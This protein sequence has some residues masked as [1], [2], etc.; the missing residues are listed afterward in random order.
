MSKPRPDQPEPEAKRQK[1]PI[2]R[3][4]RWPLRA[5]FG[6]VAS[7]LLYILSAAVLGLIP[8]NSD[9]IQATSGR[10]VYVI[11]NG[12]HTSFILP[13]GNGAENL[14][15]FVPFEKATDVNCRYVQFGWG[16]R[17]F[18]L[19]TPNWS[20]LEVSTALKSVLLPSSTVVHVTYW[21]WQPQPNER[22]RRI[23]LSDT[24][25]GRLLDHIKNSFTFDPSG[26]TQ[27][28]PGAGY[29]DRDAFFEAQGSYSLL[30]TCNDWTNTGLKHA[31]V[32]TAL[33]SPFDQAILYH[34]PL[35][36]GR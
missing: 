25:Y 10:D 23:L 7:L 14:L 34:R 6:F 12:V 27:P 5:L 28:I 32:K 35:P 2:R 33:W 24:E 19:D 36:K 15:R 3:F 22:I 1:G 26:K 4:L 30:H 17:G 20:D 9:W 21:R 29:S 31:G 8:V 11:S 18:Y 16:D 13:R